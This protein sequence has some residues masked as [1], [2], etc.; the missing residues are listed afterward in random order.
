MTVDESLN[1]MHAEF[2]NVREEIA[3]FRS[4]MTAEFTNV[5]AELAGLRTELKFEGETTRRHFDVM[6]EQMRDIVK[7]VAD[8]TVRNTER[9][10]DHEQRIKAIEPPGL[11]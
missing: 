11:A 1:E 2:K 7:V 8:G 5:R 10:D 3:G 9:L 4:D 6:V